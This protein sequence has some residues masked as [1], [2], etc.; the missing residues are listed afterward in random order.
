MAGT[1]ETKIERTNPAIATI[2]KD[3]L[4]I[5]FAD[6]GT[7]KQAVRKLNSEGIEIYGKADIKK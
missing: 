6:R 5:E 7:F 2:D 3:A 1:V 4:T